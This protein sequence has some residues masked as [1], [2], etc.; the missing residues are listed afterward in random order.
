MRTLVFIDKNAE[1]IKDESVFIPI[2]EDDSG[3]V[4]RDIAAL[5]KS[6]Y[7]EVAGG[8]LL[9]WLTDLFCN[10]QP[11]DCYVARFGPAGGIGAA[12]AFTDDVKEELNALYEKTKAVAY[13][14]TILCQSFA[15]ETLIP[16]IALFFAQCCAR[17]RTL[18]SAAPY[19]PCVMGTIGDLNS[20]AVYSL[21]KTAGADAFMCAHMD[22]E[23]NGA[24]FQLGLALN[25]VNAS[26]TP[27]GDS[28]DMVATNLITPSGQPDPD[29]PDFTI[30]DWEDYNFNPSVQK[31]LEDNH[32]AY[33]R[34]VG[35]GSGNVHAVG[36]ETI[37]GNV[38]QADWVVCFC[39]YVNK[40][41]VAQIIT[42]KNARR[43]S[44]TYN[45]IL[46]VMMGTVGR[47]GD[48]GSGIL[49]HV[50]NSA[51]AFANLPPS[52]GREIVIPNAWSAEYV[53]GVR[54]VRVYGTLTLAK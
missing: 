3:D 37:R 4:L 15:D 10:G 16:E 29:T 42:R 21:L 47:F 45:E 5:T 44:R 36:D 33:F 31:M 26:G 23:R 41:R 51:P 13:H 28:I 6:N 54:S 14:K 39:N 22:S 2:D 30:S 27:V 50:M 38:M 53:F 34:T 24:L 12:S 1:Y 32:I 8:R 46:T 19:Y 43:N 49:T 9:T 7:A 52:G 48:N 40:V 25:G 17:D 11:F 18:L 35:D 20:D